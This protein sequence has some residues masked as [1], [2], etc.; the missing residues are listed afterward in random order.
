MQAKLDVAQGGAA[1]APVHPYSAS[2]KRTAIT[3]II[4]AADG[5]A[6]LAGTTLTTGGWVK[7][8][9]SGG[10]GAFAFI[11]I[12][13]GSCFDDL[14]VRLC[15]SQPGHHIPVSASSRVPDDAARRPSIRHHITPQVAVHTVRRLSSA[16]VRPAVTAEDS[17]LGRSRGMPEHNTACAGSGGAP[18]MARTGS[19]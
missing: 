3:K 7:S 6:S 9:R 11:S 14:Q 16:A 17:Y 18:H 15:H 4:S 5:G 12:N 8:G 13:D 10:G 19:R 2:Y 1:T